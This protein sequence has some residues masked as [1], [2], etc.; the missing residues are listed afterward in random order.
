MAD[1]LYL[2]SLSYDEPWHHQATHVMTRSDG[3]SPHC[4][5]T[6]DHCEQSPMCTGMPPHDQPALPLPIPLP[7]SALLNFPSDLPLATGLFPGHTDP[8]DSRR[9]HSLKGNLSLT[10]KSH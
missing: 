8:Q 7:T 3:F 5:D 2:L 1:G 4:H 10:A 9:L 6:G